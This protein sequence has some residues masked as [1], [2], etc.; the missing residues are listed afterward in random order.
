MS[1]AFRLNGIFSDVLENTLWSIKC[2]RYKALIEFFIS[3]QIEHGFETF[4][5][6]LDD[7]YKRKG[8][9]KYLIRRKM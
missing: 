1:T 3:F 9:Y 6:G 2:R 4:N 5:L 7:F 8:Q